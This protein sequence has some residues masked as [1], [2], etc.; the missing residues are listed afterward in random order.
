[1]VIYNVDTKENKM[2]T[3][4]KLNHNVLKL[5]YSVSIKLPFLQK[6]KGDLKPVLF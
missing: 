2:W 4:V 1:M 5:P 3:K 6:D